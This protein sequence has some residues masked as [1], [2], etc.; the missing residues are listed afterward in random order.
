LPTQ[1]H[2][3]S[4]S[5]SYD[6]AVTADLIEAFLGPDDTGRP[7]LHLLR[8]PYL[9]VAGVRHEIPEGGKRLL[10]YIALHGG[11]LDRRRLAGKLWPGAGD[12]RAAGNLRSALWRLRHAHLDIIDVSRSAVSLRPAVHVDVDLVARWSAG[13]ITCT[14]L[15]RDLLATLSGV[16]A[17]A[18]LPGWYDDWVLVERERLRNRMLDGMEKLSRQL[19]LA[20]RYADGVDA[21][22]I[23]V[24]AEPLRDSAQRA[25]L[26]AHL[27]EGN[28]AEARAGFLAY[29]RIL[30]RELGVEP[31]AQLAALLGLGHQPGRGLRPTLA[32]GDADV[33]GHQV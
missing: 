2:C 6:A 11:R 25:L 13:P 7:V 29:R 1:H 5:A 4:R 20:G 17:L 30:L 21:A 23:A 31:D 16:D 24:A 27:A 14:V 28:W 18:L 15:R 10:A 19:V 12:D 26:E 3:R 9:T 33:V 32:R 8:G 22:M